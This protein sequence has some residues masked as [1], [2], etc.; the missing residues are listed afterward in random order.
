MRQIEHATPDPFRTT[1]PRN[2]GPRAYYGV[3]HRNVG[4]P[5]EP[6]FAGEGAESL[7]LALATTV[8]PA[9][10]PGG[11]GNEA[12]GLE[13]ASGTNNSGAGLDDPDDGWS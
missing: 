7:A 2:T 9:E 3:F 10:V 12:M 4:L 8:L 6:E 5:C 11:G 1:P 13:P